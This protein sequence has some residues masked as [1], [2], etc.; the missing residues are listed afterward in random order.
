MNSIENS[1]NFIFSKMLFFS[2]KVLFMFFF[3]LEKK[4]IVGNKKL[5]WL[6]VFNRC[7]MYPQRL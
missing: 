3:Y 1:H 2:N 7:C 6:D 5:V 4:L